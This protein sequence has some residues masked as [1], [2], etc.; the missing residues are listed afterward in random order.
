MENKTG[1]NEESQGNGLDE[2]VLFRGTLEELNAQD[3]SKQYEFA[4]K[5]PKEHR[6]MVLYKIL[7]G[8]M[9]EGMADHIRDNALR[10]QLVGYAG[11][12]QTHRRLVHFDD[13]E[14]M[15]HDYFGIPIRRAE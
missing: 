11:I 12:V 8:L 13:C 3:P 2:L 9:P 14:G 6:F 1:R 15:G 7:P 10:S 4:E 5:E